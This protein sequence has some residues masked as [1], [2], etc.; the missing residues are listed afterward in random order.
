[1]LELLRQLLL[2]QGF[3]EVL[4]KGVKK[5]VKSRHSDTKKGVKSRHSDTKSHNLEK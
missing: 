1:M 5:G 3:M 2:A 4:K